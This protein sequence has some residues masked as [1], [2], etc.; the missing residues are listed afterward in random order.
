MLLAVDGSMHLPILGGALRW[1]PQG[2]PSGHPAPL[3]P[4]RPLGIPQGIPRGTPS[5]PLQTGLKKIIEFT[6][7]WTKLHGLTTISA[8][9]TSGTQQALDEQN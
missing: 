4:R 1:V 5:L 8:P 7:S 9:A 2:S 6:E 3:P